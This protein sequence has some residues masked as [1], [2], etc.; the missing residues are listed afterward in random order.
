MAN[1]VLASSMTAR[2]DRRHRTTSGYDVELT[3]LA[4]LAIGLQLGSMLH[5][6]YR[7]L[8]VS[9]GAAGARSL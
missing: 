1:A 6:L 4:V 3:E 2:R 9:G 7:L 5:D 8:V